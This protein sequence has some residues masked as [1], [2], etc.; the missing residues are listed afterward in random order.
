MTG[1]IPR[2]LA[3]PTLTSLK[4][5]NN[6]FS[7]RI[8]DYPFDGTTFAQFRVDGNRLYG[9][10]PQFET[11]I[12]TKDRDFDILPGAE[13]SGNFIADSHSC[14]E[15]ND[16]CSAGQSSCSP[17]NEICCGAVWDAPHVRETCSSGECDV[18][19]GECVVPYP[20]ISPTLNK[21]QAEIETL[22]PFSFFNSTTAPSLDFNTTQATRPEAYVFD[23][24]LLQVTLFFC[25]GAFLVVAGYMA[26]E[27]NNN[28]TRPR[29]TLLRSVVGRKEQRHSP[30]T[31]MRSPHQP[32]L[33][34]DRNPMLLVPD[35]GDTNKDDRAWDQR[36][37]LVIQ[38]ENVNNRVSRIP[39]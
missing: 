15:N 14:K 12:D 33:R 5:S 4:L 2:A 6:A 24:T 11:A 23:S 26:K 10:A 32:E 35:F 22:A 3:R 25:I 19:T 18:E 30:P 36:R 20:T 34:V 17:V 1:T 27:R 37:K 9:S 28:H 38:Q 13:F 7:G 8:S 29:M 31:D 39:F 21:G 16:L